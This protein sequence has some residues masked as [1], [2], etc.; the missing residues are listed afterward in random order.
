MCTNRALSCVIISTISKRTESSSLM[1]HHLGVPSG[2]SKMISEPMV[3]LTQT[4]HLS[5]IDPNIVS[6]RIEMRFHMT[7]VIEEFYQVCRKQ[8][9]SLWYVQRK[10]YT[11]LMSRL[12]L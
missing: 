1:P 12:A 2:A 6:K 11:Y 3:R 9:L 7:Y 5:C 8:F 4:K 10:P